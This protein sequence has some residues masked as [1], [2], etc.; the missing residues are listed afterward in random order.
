VGFDKTINNISKE[1]LV[2]ERGFPVPSMDDHLAAVEIRTGHEADLDGFSHVKIYLV[3]PAEPGA[4]FLSFPGGPG[5]V[6]ACHLNFF[7]HDLVLPAGFGL[8]LLKH[9]Q[10]CKPVSP[11]NRPIHSACRSPNRPPGACIPDHL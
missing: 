6:V 2:I 3:D 5:S 9:H 4:G 11:E 7:Y 8:I 1:L 10:K